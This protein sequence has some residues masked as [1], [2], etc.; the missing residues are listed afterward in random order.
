MAGVFFAAKIILTVSEAMIILSE[1]RVTAVHFASGNMTDRE[2]KW[3][4]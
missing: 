4:K 1:N 3:G 2:E